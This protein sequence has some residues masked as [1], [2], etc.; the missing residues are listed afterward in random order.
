MAKKR[1]SKQTKQADTDGNQAWCIMRRT[2]Q[3][4]QYEPFVLEL[5]I[6]LS[7]ENREHADQRL[8]DAIRMVEGR[9]QDEMDELVN[10]L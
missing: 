10:S 9:M 5:G 6:S 8:Q 1:R 7:V 4:Q 2:V 3:I